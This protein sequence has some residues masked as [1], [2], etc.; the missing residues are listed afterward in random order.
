MWTIH[1]IAGTKNSLDILHRT[2]FEFDSD[3]R[4]WVRL[5]FNNTSNNIIAELMKVLDT[6]LVIDLHADVKTLRAVTIIFTLC[7]AVLFCAHWYGE[8]AYNVTKSQL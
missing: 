1:K 8:K 6:A 5:L 2:L 4:Q 3:T 7:N